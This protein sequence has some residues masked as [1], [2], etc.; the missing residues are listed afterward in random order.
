MFTIKA[1]VKFSP[2]HGLG[3][4]AEQDIKKG[5]VV[6]RFDPR[7]DLEFEEAS[8]GNLPPVTEE[9]LRMYTYGQ[10]TNGKKMVVLCGDHAR[11]MNHSDHANVLEEGHDP[12]INIA[13][14]D[15][16]KGEELTCDYNSFDLNVGQK[17]YE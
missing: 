7:F 3:C 11:H 6:W 1:S 14:R 16:K 17:I 12:G 5:E 13:G 4:F 15:I 10:I 8:L 9:Y 2:I